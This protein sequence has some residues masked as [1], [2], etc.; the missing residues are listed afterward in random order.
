MLVNPPA[1]AD[2]A[3]ANDHHRQIECGTDD[4]G[5]RII[6]DAGRAIRPAQDIGASR[7]AFL[8]ERMIVRRVDWRL[9]I[10]H[11]EA[12]MRTRKGGHLLHHGFGGKAGHQ[13]HIDIAGCFRRNEWGPDPASD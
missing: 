9:H 3:R 10:E 1:H 12:D 13:P 4:G 5:I 6:S 7:Q 2:L 11:F 8:D